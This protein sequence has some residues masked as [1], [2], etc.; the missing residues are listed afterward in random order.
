MPLPQVIVEPSNEK[1]K[2]AKVIE[3]ERMTNS[4]GMVVNSSD[5]DFSIISSTDNRTNLMR[6]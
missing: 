5:D 6:A 3:G 1:M 2:D 4:S